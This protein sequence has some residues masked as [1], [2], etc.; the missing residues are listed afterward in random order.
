MRTAVILA[1]VLILAGAV[2]AAPPR[3][4]FPKLDLQRYADLREAERY[5]MD[6]ADKLFG[7]EKWQAAQAEYEKF[8]KV[9]PKSIGLA[10]AQLRIAECQEYQLFTNTAIDEYKAVPKF[11][12]KSPEAPLAAFAIGR[13]LEAAGEFEK[14]IDQYDA[15][16][17][18]YPKAT[19]CGDALWAGADLA[20]RKNKLDVAVQFRR[21]IVSDYA[22]SNRMANAAYWLTQHYLLAE[23]N[24]DAA[25]E[26]ALKVLDPTYAE[27][28]LGDLLLERARQGD[29]DAAGWAD[30]AVERYKAVLAQWPKSGHAHESSHA[31]IECYR[32]TDR[33]KEALAAVRD[34]LA[35]YPDDDQARYLAGIMLE[36][37][38]KWDD[39]R[40]VW[41][42]QYHN[43]AEGAWQVAE[44]YHRQRKYDQAEA[45]Y[46]G[47]LTTYPKMSATVLNRAGE[48]HLHGTGNYE[49]AVSF[50]RQSEYNPPHYLFQVAESYRR[51]GKLDEALRT[52]AEIRGFFPD[53]A[54]EAMWRQAHVYEQRKKQGDDSLAIGVLKKICDDHP[55]SPQSSLAHHRLQDVY[56]ISY[57]GGAMK[58]R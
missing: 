19:I 16:C 20:Q 43:K 48:M 18:D 39:A 24:T 37:Q 26:F 1:T 46:I 12:P 7:Q 11:F 34:H 49:K 41:F 35:L 44:S 30:L 10:F 29:K 9:Y 25:R 15:V 6:V 57:T 2:A 32:R 14:A 56:K 21:R 3:E 45:A 5:Q 55:R 47:M 4:T 42:L 33:I 27:R 36:R 53:N 8:L 17:R 58:E 31:I 22:Q 51:W 40:N 28:Y 54:P 50:F 13:C 52:L 23:K 38:G